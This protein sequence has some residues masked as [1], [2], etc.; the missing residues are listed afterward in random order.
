MGGERLFVDYSGLINLALVTIIY[1]T[2]LGPSL[3]KLGEL[4]DE[5][6]TTDFP[7]HEQQNASASQKVVDA[8]IALDKKIKQYTNKFG[9]ITRFLKYFYSI[10][11]VLLI[12]QIA[13]TII[14]A[15][16]SFPNIASMAA[17]IIVVG[18]LVLTVNTHMTPIW[19]VRSIPWLADSGFTP[20]HLRTIFNPQLCVNNRVA[21]KDYESDDIGLSLVSSIE[22]LGYHYIL[23]IESTDG[24][25]LYSI[26]SGKIAKHV[27]GQDLITA[28]NRQFYEVFLASPKLKNGSYQARLIVFDAPFPGTFPAT[29]VLLNFAVSPTTVDAKQ[30]K[31][32]LTV[33]S[34]SYSIET[35]K[36]KPKKISFK[37]GIPGDRSIITLLSSRAFIRHFLA[38][39]R[40]A[41]TTSVN[42]DLGRFEIAK[43]YSRR[44]I[45]LR[46]IWRLRK[47]R[48]RAIY[49]PL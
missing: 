1:S 4:R 19:R 39:R 23:T 28:D 13:L 47:F 44:H 38:D 48:K 15:N 22:L 40:P 46:N 27:S 14:Q 20:T 8:G 2:F 18:F 26:S 10:L 49:L 11:A 17:A 42:G 45:L 6:L 33:A 5:I 7:K 35:K 25:R 41:I 12:A 31:V 36:G 3:K 32:D 9:E 30:V 37:E 34:D 43:R 16:Y 21:N 29:E 24:Q